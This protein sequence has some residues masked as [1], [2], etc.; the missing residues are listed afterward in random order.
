MQFEKRTSIIS[1]D[2][3]MRQ[4]F[5]KHVNNALGLR[6]MGYTCALAARKY[7]LVFL[8]VES[9]HF[10][11]YD[12]GL[13]SSYIIKM[14]GVACLI[15]YDY[16]IAPTLRLCVS[17]FFNFHHCPYCFQNVLHHC[18]GLCKQSRDIGTNILEILGQLYKVKKRRANS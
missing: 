10:K 7:S 3:K 5:S 17:I 6:C 8:R 11:T 15:I 14:E 1:Q 13:I 4:G 16:D 18:P 9:L 2:Y 12:I